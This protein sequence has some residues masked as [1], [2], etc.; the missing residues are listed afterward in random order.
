MSAP[1]TVSKPTGPP[2]DSEAVGSDADSDSSSSVDSQ[3]EEDRLAK[4]EW[5]RLVS[6]TQ[7]LIGLAVPFMAAYWGRRA[8]FKIVH[9]YIALGFTKAFWFGWTGLLGR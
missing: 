5:D 8:G 3:E 6:Q 2:S 9:R 4:E 1:Q 7:L